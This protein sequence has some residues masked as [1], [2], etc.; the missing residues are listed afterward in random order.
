MM[1]LEANIDAVILRQLLGKRRRGW[2]EL[3]RR[4]KGRFVV[5]GEGGG[6]RGNSLIGTYSVQL[7]M[8]VSTK[9]SPSVT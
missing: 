4:K 6:L 5:W 1:K 3:V 2:C 9:C 7:Q 8:N